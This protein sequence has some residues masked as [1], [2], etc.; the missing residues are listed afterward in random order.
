MAVQLRH[1]VQAAT[2]PNVTL[3]VIPDAS[4]WHPALEG[5]FSLI[6]LRSGVTIV[7]LENRRSAL[8]LHEKDDVAAYRDAVAV[9]LGSV[10]G[11]E[12]SVARIA[13]E[14]RRIE[15]EP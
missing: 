3:R 9:V 13:R 11:S 1:L 12:E 7:H 10:M 5:P 2:L 6:E 14:L 15:R 8:F 4:D